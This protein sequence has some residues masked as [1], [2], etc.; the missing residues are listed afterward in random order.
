MMKVVGPGMLQT[1]EHSAVGQLNKIW[2]AWV[3]L[4]DEI[5][6]DKKKIFKKKWKKM[7]KIYKNKLAISLT[8]RENYWIS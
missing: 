2:D 5:V 7:Q 3:E 6:I 1:E 8:N 4:S